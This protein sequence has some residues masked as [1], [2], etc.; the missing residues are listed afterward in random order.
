MSTEACHFPNVGWV[1]DDTP[2]QVRE[3]IERDIG[4][5]SGEDFRYE[6]AGHTEGAWV[7]PEASGSAAVEQ[8]LLSL[9]TAYDEAFPAYR[10]TICHNKTPL[11][12]E[13]DRVWVNYQ[14]KHDFNPMHWHDGVFSFVTWVAIPYDVEQ[15]AGRWDCNNPKAGQFSFTV[16][17][18]LG[19][20]HDHP[21][22]QREW[23]T[24]FFPAK[25]RHKVHP[26]YTSDMIRVSI[27]GNLVLV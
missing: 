27:S 25:M 24:L 21:V 1:E 5:E 4:A 13:L 8:W 12:L 19:E 22:E 3:L 20:I 26:F 11:S 14:V 2:A 23:K 9:A 16:T 18:A 10:T 15:E 17:D 6:L 7:L